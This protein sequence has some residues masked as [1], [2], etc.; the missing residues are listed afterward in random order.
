MLDRFGTLDI[1]SESSWLNVATARTRNADSNRIEVRISEPQLELTGLSFNSLL[2]GLF[3]CHS[4]F[5]D[6]SIK[7]IG[8]HDPW[9]VVV[10]G[11]GPSLFSIASTTEVFS[12]ID[13]LLE[14]FV[15]HQQ[16]FHAKADHTKHREG[17]SVERKRKSMALDQLILTDGA[18][19]YIK[20]WAQH[21]ERYLSDVQIVEFKAY[22]L[23]IAAK[24][25]VIGGESK[26]L[27]LSIYAMGGKDIAA[28]AKAL[29][30]SA[31]GTCRD[32]LILFAKNAKLR[33][34][35]NCGIRYGLNMHKE[36][37]IAEEIL[38]PSVLHIPSASVPFAPYY[39][40]DEEAKKR[41]NTQKNLT[42]ALGEEINF[43]G[44]SD[45]L[46]DF[47]DDEPE[48]MDDAYHDPT[49]PRIPEGK[50]S[51][52][53]PSSFDIWTIDP[54]EIARQSTLVDHN[55]FL[56]IPPELFM[57][58][59]HDKPRHLLTAT[60]VR[61]FIDRFNAISVWVTASVLSGRSP[62]N[63]VIIYEHIVEIALHYEQ[64]SNFSALT[65]VLT[66]LQQGSVMRLK[67]TLKLVSPAI[68]KKLEDLAELMKGDKNYFRYRS[69]LMKRAHSHD[70]FACVP[71]LGAHLALMTS[72][73]ESND[74][75][76]V[77]S[78]HLLN[79]SKIYFNARALEQLIS[80][81]TYRYDILAVRTVAAAF[82][83]HLN[84]YVFCSTVLPFF[85]VCDVSVSFSLIYLF[86]LLAC[87]L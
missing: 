22:M 9:R 76:I 55:L 28:K 54:I 38:T 69:Q 3:L 12:R 53:A 78:P 45:A 70:N 49:L 27:L 68:N 60:A 7:L 15:Y 66:G 80:L 56:Q 51:F 42:A 50:T 41:S 4:T 75:H 46:L 26:D 48:D 85:L 19:R 81:Q 57:S 30:H 8:S 31:R 61:R 74:E 72:I 16:V 67:E 25:G 13:Y 2:L 37:D 62:E 10:K 24:L 11:V 36:I 21:Y 34:L 35:Q 14:D 59:L 83:L 6:S 77:D 82:D 23:D 32:C 86:L 73:D 87:I 65:A 20:W 79:L 33:F 17:K 1:I 44:G 40:F 5:R 18:V 29:V 84:K 43:F 71:H 47:D 58:N 52:S 63:R 39:E 64:L